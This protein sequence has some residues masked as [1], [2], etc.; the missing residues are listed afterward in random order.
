MR[1]S[2][3]SSVEANFSTLLDMCLTLDSRQ[4][5]QQIKPIYCKTYG[6]DFIFNDQKQ[7]LLHVL[8]GMPRFRNWQVLLK[9]FLYLDLT[10]SFQQTALFIAVKEKNF[11]AIESLVNNEAS[12]LIEDEHGINAIQYACHTH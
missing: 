5:H 12:P 1:I 11:Y 8:A 2:E 4:L 10:D 7:N 3:H 9:G 6:L